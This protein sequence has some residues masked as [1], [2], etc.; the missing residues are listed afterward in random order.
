LKKPL[1]YLENIQEFQCVAITQR[2]SFFEV[3]DPVVLICGQW[4][5][6]CVVHGLWSMVFLYLA[7]FN[8]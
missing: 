6:V 1:L 5:L 7:A 3:R 4:S 8:F 2:V